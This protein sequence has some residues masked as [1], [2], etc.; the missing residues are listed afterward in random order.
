[1]AKLKVIKKTTMAEMPNDEEKNPP[2]KQ[3]VYS[4]TS[5]QLDKIVTIDTMGYSAGAKKFPI[6]MQYARGGI[7]QKKINR[8]QVD[9]AIK[10]P[11]EVGYEPGVSASERMNMKKRIVESNKEQ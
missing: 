6:L 10:N 7:K 5:G 11:I 2:V 1:M 3:K 4:P 9:R 8:K